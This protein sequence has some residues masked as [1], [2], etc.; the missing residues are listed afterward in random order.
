MGQA[1]VRALR[2]FV[3]SREPEERCDTCGGALVTEHHHTF[4]PVSRRIRCACNV[5]ATV[6][7]TAYKLIP[8]RVQLLRDFQMSDTQWDDLLIPIGLAF[9]SYSSAAERTIALY[10]GPA[11]A[12]ESTLRLAAW[13]EIVA[14]N[15][16]LYTMQPD[17]E[18]LLV[19]RIGSAREHF[20]VPVDECYKLVGLIR[21]HWRGLSG[22]A[23]VW[24]EIASFF[25]HLRRK[26]RECLG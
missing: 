15:P 20:L 3:R 7:S 16:E 18:A 4:D 17:V 11:G 2:K 12:A 13:D 8:R 25:E 10:P 24:G 21:L 9:F 19:N 6:Y 22:G 23:T 14:A 5:C 1:P 26:G